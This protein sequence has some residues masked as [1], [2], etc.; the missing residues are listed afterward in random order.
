MQTLSHQ[1]LFMLGPTQGV[2]VP[3]YDVDW[4]CKPRLF[5]LGIPAEADAW[6]SFCAAYPDVK[7]DDHLEA[8]VCEL[9]GVLDPPAKLTDAGRLERAALHMA[10][11][12][13]AAAYG[14]WVYYPWLQRAIKVLPEAEFV[15]VRTNRNLYKIT[16]SEQ[17][18][19]DKKAI[20]V[21]GMSV[22]RALHVC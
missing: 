1:T 4:S 17:E 6:E 16:P 7:Y 21:I 15:R 9:M 19:L 13:G 22:G 14:T 18:E 20:G 11:R 8:Q 2:G 5:R 3:E 12:G 10:E